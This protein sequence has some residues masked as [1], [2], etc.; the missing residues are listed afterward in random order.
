MKSPA[1]SYR[2]KMLSELATRCSIAVSARPGAGRRVIVATRNPCL[3]AALEELARA[4]IHHPAIARGGRHVQ[5]RWTNRTGALRVQHRR[6][7]VRLESAG[8]R[9]A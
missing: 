6:N 5:V 4:G 2:T 3:Q 9:Q 1:S 7:A 8:K